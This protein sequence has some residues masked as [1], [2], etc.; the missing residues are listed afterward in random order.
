MAS[1][2]KRKRKL[3]GKEVEARKYTIQ[4]TDANGQT[5]RVTG[6][7]DKMRSWELA[8]QLESGEAEANHVRHRK[9]PLLDHLEEFK[10]SLLASGSS[11][12]HVSKTC[13]RAKKVIKGCE[14]HRITNLD[15][16]KVEVW[17]EEQRNREKKPIG[18][19]TSNHYLV[20]MKQFAK[21]LVDNH[22]A[23]S[24]PLARLSK[25]NAETDVRRI[26]RTLTDEE[27][28]K[29]I[30]AT[31][32]GDDY[33]DVSGADRAMLYLLATNTGLRASELA[34]LT[35]DSFKLKGED[36]SVTVEAAYSK[37]KRKD[38]LP[39]RPDVAQ[40]LRGWLVGRSGLLWPGPWVGRAAEMIRV[41]LK[42][43]DIEY[44]VKGAVFDFHALRHQFISNLA[45]AG[46]H[47]KVAQKLARH[48][49]IVLTMDRYAHLD[50]PQ[51]VEGLN[52]LPKPALPAKWTQK[53]TQNG[54]FDGPEVPQ[55]GT[56]EGATSDDNNNGQPLELQEVGV[57]CHD[58]S[59]DDAN[60]PA[61]TR[62]WDQGI[63]SPLL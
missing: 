57:G 3:Y 49:T 40:A 7:T 13:S 4:Y 6:Y 38:V 1:V 10:K 56:S 14:F 44:E 12:K 23:A 21:W 16:T 55:H 35:P 45:K 36:P 17:L 34:S 60:R 28:A 31:L 18:I 43:A 63:M 58:A 25:L 8:K 61:R 22:R 59:D 54:D 33:D 46:V 42:A 47:P 2:F 15:A 26:R 27:F 20:S 53:W 24:N 29:F 50:T 37:H 39:L 51:L 11:A 41:D 30:Q 5:R 52:R 19:K 9:T 62:T 32:D 48:S